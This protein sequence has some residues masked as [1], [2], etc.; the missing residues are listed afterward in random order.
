MGHSSPQRPRGANNQWGS[1]FPKPVSWRKGH[2]RVASRRTDRR[3]RKRAG[4]ALAL[5]C[6]ISLSGSLS[7]QQASDQA[8]RQ[9]LQLLGE[10]ATTL[11]HALP[12]FTCQEKALS[13]KLRGKKVL[14]GTQFVATLRAQRTANGSLDESI[15]ITSV[16]GQPFTNGHFHMPLFVRGGFDQMMRYFA[17]QQQAC[18]RYSLAPG[19]VNFQS[20]P[21]ADPLICKDSGGTGFALLDA[22]GNAIR[23]ERH[24]DPEMAR[25]RQAATYAADDIAPIELNGQTYRLARHLYDEVPQ[26]N[27]TYAFTADYTDCRL[28]TAT[29]TISPATSSAPPE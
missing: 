2:L 16:N 5:G 6:A 13:Q 7:A 22:K 1:I 18:Y 24:V 17:P 20:I 12:G 27:D 26:G 3:N 28:F 25:S 4:L 9:E 10:A 23:I 15:S 14:Q 8:L 29:I 21:G 19:R 11:E